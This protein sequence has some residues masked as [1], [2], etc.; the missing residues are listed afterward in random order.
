MSESCV[1]YCHSWNGEDFK[2]GTFDSVKAAL[3]DA[4]ADNDEGHTI[5]HIG[6]VDRPCNSQ[7]FPDAGDVIEHMENQSY[8]YGGE[9]AMDYLDVSDEAKAELDA[10]L[11][12]LLDAWCK[13]HDVSPNFYQVVGAKEYPISSSPS[14]EG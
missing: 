13:K 8:D 10:Q 1:E 11:A 3:A 9:Y 6:K 2:S 12:D 4:A 14:Q 7:F 5:V